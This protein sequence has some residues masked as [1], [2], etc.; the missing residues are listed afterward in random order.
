[1]CGQRVQL[2]A[3][4]SGEPRRR[5]E[6]GLS[7]AA[8][9]AERSEQRYLLHHHA[10]QVDRLRRAERTEDDHPT[11]APH[12]AQGV[13]DGVGRPADAFHDDIG[14]V[15]LA[16]AHRLVLAQHHHAELFGGSSLVRV[17]RRDRDTGGAIAGHE[18]GAQP[19]RACPQH[20]HGVVGSDIREPDTAHRHRQRFCQR[21]R[22]GV[23]AVRDRS[24][25]RGR[26][27]DDVGQSAVASEAESGPALAA[28]VRAAGSAELTRA[29]H[30]VG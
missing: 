7:L 8:A 14:P 27:V 26:R 2:V 4:S 13:V 24:E 29:A 6:L 3:P 28:Q 19:D 15:L 9:V 20:Q 22:D 21:C 10:L 1:M 18:R 5:R 17:A 30:D 25:V 12:D 16:P 11:T 23:D